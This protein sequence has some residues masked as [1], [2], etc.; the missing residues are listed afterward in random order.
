M[1]KLYFG[2]D[3]FLIDGRHKFAKI[4]LIYCYFTGNTFMDF[5]KVH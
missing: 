5:R 1:N 4:Q 2:R 3:F